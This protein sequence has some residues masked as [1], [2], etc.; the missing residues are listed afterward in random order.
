MKQLRIPVPS[1]RVTR[2]AVLVLILAISCTF[3]YVALRLLDLSN[4]VVDLKTES[5]NNATAARALARQV[6]NLGGTPVVTPPPAGQTGPA[7]GVG[8]QG[9]PG[10]QG[11]EGLMGPQGQTG[12]H[13]ARGSTGPVG[14]TGPAGPEGAV[15]PQGPQGDTGPQG[16]AG[17]DGTN[18][19]DGRN[20]P[21]ITAVAFSGDP[22]A[23][24]LDVT[25]SDGTVLTTP[26]PTS[27]CTPPP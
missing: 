10:P 26:V 12:P 22:S 3:A 7:G 25:L 18:G 1:G 11:P 17:T 15:G 9:P 13:G 21:T 23:C 8:P 14:S 2:L 27:F 19:T 4:Q 6:R 20:A 5:A 24:E 16:P